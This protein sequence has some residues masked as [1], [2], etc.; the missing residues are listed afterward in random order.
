VSKSERREVSSGSWAAG[1]NR[2][3]LAFYRQI[4][5]GGEQREVMSDVTEGVGSHVRAKLEAIDRPDACD[6]TQ[7]C[8]SAGTLAH[9][10]AR[11]ADVPSS[12][13]ELR[14]QGLFDEEAVPFD[15]VLV[16]LM[17]RCE[18]VICRLGA[19]QLGRLAATLPDE[20]RRAL[21]SGLG[22]PGSSGRQLFEA[23]AE[24]SGPTGEERV[25]LA[26]VYVTET[27]R[28]GRQAPS[29]DSSAT[30]EDR[31]IE[32]LGWCVV[33]GAAS[34]HYAQ[35][36]AAM[37]R[38]CAAPVARRLR[39]HVQM[40]GL[41]SR[42]GLE[43]AHVSALGLYVETDERWLDGVVEHSGGDDE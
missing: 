30:S 25:R 20:K 41:T 7:V 28:T 39:R 23:A 16:A 42:R 22:E 1:L 26:E 15:R 11:L 40:A 38:S 27:E 35:R 18:Q 43:S 33:A 3:E 2:S 24:T 6:G 13:G 37:E 8:S 10:R 34:G 31:A 14:E 21:A 12:I 4:V 19:F 5:G 36:L 17:G 32:S 9:L 29:R